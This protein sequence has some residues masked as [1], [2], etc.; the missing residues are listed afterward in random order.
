MRCSFYV[1]A[2][3]FSIS[4]AAQASPSIECFKAAMADPQVFSELKSMPDKFGNKDL[5]IEEYVGLLCAGAAGPTIPINC[6]KEVV[7]DPQ[8]FPHSKMHHSWYVKVTS[9][10]AVGAR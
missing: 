7:R 10:C 5:L 8:V 3:A 2:T 9:L 6:Y 4:M 1:L